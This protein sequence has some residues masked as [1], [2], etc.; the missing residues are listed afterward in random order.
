MATETTLDLQENDQPAKD[1]LCAKSKSGSERTCA[2]EEVAAMGS[3]PANSGNRARALRSSFL[4][5]TARRTPTADIHLAGDEQNSQDFIVRSRTDD[6]LRR[7]VR[8]WLRLSRV[9]IELFVDRNWARR[10][11]TCRRS[12][13]G[14]HVAN[15]AGRCAQA[16]DD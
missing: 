16:A 3:L 8:A 13:S 12:A 5:S 2:F 7:A 11:R 14:A 4:P 6:G 10:K 15:T 1:R 9:A